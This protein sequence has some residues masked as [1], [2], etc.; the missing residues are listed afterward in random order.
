MIEVDQSP[1][2][3]G[4]R[5]VD[6]SE[7]MSSSMNTIAAACVALA[8]TVFGANQAHDAY[9][10]YQF[11]QGIERLAVETQASREKAEAEREHR[12]ADERA[13]AAEAAARVEAAANAQRSNA[14]MAATVRCIQATRAEV[15]AAAQPTDDRKLLDDGAWQMAE[16][17][18]EIV[19]DRSKGTWEYRDVIARQARR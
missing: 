18:C 4:T 8:A 13:K 5:G 15:M 3:V 7:R 9:R 12:Q 1:L 11:E 10:R 17:R 2:Q 16:A 6:M 14:R 19:H